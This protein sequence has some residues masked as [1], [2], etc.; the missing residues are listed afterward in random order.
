MT[1][2]INVNVPVG[3]SL[4]AQQDLVKFISQAI[5]QSGSFAQSDMQSV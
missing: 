1:N 4:I 2:H 5:G 3:G